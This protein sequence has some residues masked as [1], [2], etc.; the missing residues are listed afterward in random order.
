MT[1]APSP[2][3]N[4]VPRIGSALR[5][6]WRI[7]VEKPRTAMWT[8]AAVT[9]ALFAV[10]LAVLA[11][12]N[13]DRWT[14]GPRGAASMVVYLAEGVDEP[15]ARE[16]IAQLA[17]LSGVE[18]VE[19]VTPAESAKRLQQAVGA[20]SALLD[21]VELAAMPASVEVTLAP[22]VRDVIAMSPTVRALRGAPGIDD[23][24]VE[25]N[26]ADRVAGTLATVRLVAWTGAALF[27][28]LALIIA[29]AALRVRL[30]RGKH[31]LA[32][33][34]LLGAAPAFT[35]VPTALAGALHGVIAAI[36]GALALWG[37][38]ALYGDSITSALRG[39][40]GAVELAVP[41]VPQLVLF[42][43]LGAILGLVGGGL[44]GATRATR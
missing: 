1:G 30:E 39:A 5:R 44:A 12:V 6:A 17:K 43:G 13:L 25:D 21:G 19:L 22:G 10:G 14:S 24:I 34:H 7:A 36:V 26:G 16:L 41:A 42:V 23:V 40:L 11:A 20:D 35:I 8:L 37:A 27:A 38:V 33:A 3:G 32:V 29:L 2:R 4:S 28:G 18:Q 15:H 9:C 31:E